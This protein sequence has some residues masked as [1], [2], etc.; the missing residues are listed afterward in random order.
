MRQY[1]QSV[2]KANGIKNSIALENSNATDEI[3]GLT[4][5]GSSQPAPQEKNILEM[6]EDEVR[7]E[8]RKYR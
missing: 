5:V 3:A 6:T 1:A 2:I 7:K 4:G 8:L